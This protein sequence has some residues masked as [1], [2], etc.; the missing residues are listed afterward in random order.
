MQE[1]DDRFAKHLKMLRD[2]YGSVEPLS[3]EFDIDQLGNHKQKTI[4]IEEQEVEIDEKLAGLIY[5]M[6]KIQPWCTHDSCQHNALGYYGISFTVVQFYLFCNKIYDILFKKYSKMHPLLPSD[7]LR[8]LVYQEDIMERLSV[9][10]FDNDKNK[11][12]SRIIL[13]SA[14]YAGTDNHSVNIEYMNVPSDIPKF[15][16]ELDDILN[17]FKL[18]W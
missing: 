5:K 8:V 10:G 9:N 3:K 12:G 13:H 4:M 11:S 14:G 15:E 6:N 7:N 17:T 2:Y 1:T 16:K 18:F